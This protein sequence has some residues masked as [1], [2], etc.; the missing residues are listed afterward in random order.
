[1]TGGD[2]ANPPLLGRP[3]E[4]GREFHFPVAARA[5]KR[6]HACGVALN[7]KID[8]FG[9][10]AFARINYVMGHRQLFADAGGIDEA[11]RR[12]SCPCRSSAR[13]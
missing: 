2:P 9:L 5:G 8:D 4:H 12:S 11:P 3:L 1:V 10:E 7:K 6:G 13:G